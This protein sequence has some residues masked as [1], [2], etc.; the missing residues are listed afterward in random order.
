M[1]TLKIR[2]TRGFYLHAHE[3]GSKT[4]VEVIACKRNVCTEL[5]APESHLLGKCGSQH[6]IYCVVANL[7][8]NVLLVRESESTLKHNTYT[9]V[10]YHTPRY[11]P[12]PKK[13]CVTRG[14]KAS[15]CLP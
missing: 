6:C 1:T 3:R 8:L 9:H 10:I 5:R 14:K 12:A 15:S 11:I 4:L 7:Q 13:K 2:D